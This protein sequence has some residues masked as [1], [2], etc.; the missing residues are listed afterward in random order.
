MEGSTK[1]GLFRL[2]GSARHGVLLVVGWADPAVHLLQ[3]G[4]SARV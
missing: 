4:F 1:G 2:V 3:V